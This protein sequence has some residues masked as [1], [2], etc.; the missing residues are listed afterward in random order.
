MELYGSRSK[1]RGLPAI[2]LLILTAIILVAVLDW[3]Y[4]ENAV[5]GLLLALPIAMT[6]TLDEERWVWGAAIVAA[7]A[8]LGVMYLGPPDDAAVSREVFTLN[9]VLAFLAIGFSASV[10]V[11]LQRRRLD[12]ERARDEAISVGS[13]NRILVALIAHDLRAP[14]V[15]ADQALTYSYENAIHGMPNDPE[16][17]A[18]VSARVGRSLRTIEG[19]L[20][21]ARRDVEGPRRK[22]G[23]PRSAS[24]RVKHELTEELAAFKRE[25]EDR[26]KLIDA[27]L[28]PLGD[29][30]H[31]IDGLLVRQ[32]VGI[33]VD[34]AIRYAPPGRIRVTGRLHEGDLVLGISDGGSTPVEGDTDPTGSGLG[35]AGLG[36]ELCR[37]I[38]ANAGGSLTIRRTGTGR[39][40]TLRLPLGVTPAA[41]LVP[42]AV[43]VGDR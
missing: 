33:L 37:A 30:A 1:E 41:P 7:F 13:L 6:A 39:D 42:V 35:G 5:L 38:A 12:A 14:L 23:M 3:G 22:R 11:I 34:N 2:L 26:G 24:T 32:V 25:A 29:G 18:D 15:L 4:S 31:P 43:A 10:A 36:L 17:L 20:A 28:G 40:C 16:L 19:I 9:R 21:V 8:M 27:D